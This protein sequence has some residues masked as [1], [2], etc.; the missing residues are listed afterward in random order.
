MNDIDNLIYSTARGG[1]PVNPGLPASLAYLLVSQARH[2]TGNYTSNFFRTNNNL[3]GY[4]YSGSR[5]QSG[6]GGVAD[7]GQKI[8]SYASLKDSVYELVDWIYRRRAE[9]KFPALETIQYPEQYAALLKGAGYYGD[10]LQ[11]YTAGLKSFFLE[12]PAITS[13]AGLIGVIA[14]VAVIYLIVKK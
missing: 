7:N 11:N 12:N 9:N 13:G 10:T 4:S 3:F 5:Y 8:A 14:L 6:A 1:S 2:E